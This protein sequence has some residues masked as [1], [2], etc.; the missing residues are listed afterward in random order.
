VKFNAELSGKSGIITGGAGILGQRF[1][2]AFLESNASLVIA[3]WDGDALAKM[4]SV[5]KPKFGSRISFV[6]CD[7]SNEKDVSAMVQH[8][9]KTHGKIDFLLNNAATG[10]QSVEEFFRPFED[11]SL[12]EWRRVMSV[13]IDGMFLVAKH[14]VREMKQQG[15]GGSIVQTSSIYG[16]MAS[17]N[18]I[19]DGSTFKGYSINNPAVYGASKAAV[20][21]L[22][23]WLATYL[24]T[25][26]IRV[27]AVAP[28]GVY[29]HENENFV[30][31]Y[32]ARVPMGRMADQDEITGAML[33]LV[34]EASTYMTGQC[35]MV[36]GGLSA[37]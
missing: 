18:R 4:E 37:W 32:S 24:A 6:K 1:T 17:D 2:P 21:G 31:K 5:L 15:T 28:G 8:A 33:F 29:S 36:D 14:V 7:V 13:N 11:Y 20:V 23:R 19:Y 9:K 26:K 22:T 35:L 10:P 25:D 34:S 27:N 12:E 16:V 3:D 30:R